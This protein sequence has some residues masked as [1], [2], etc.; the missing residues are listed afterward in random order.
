VFQT[1]RSDQSR[2]IQLATRSPYSHVGLVYVVD[3]E[4]MVFEAVVPVRLTPLDEW[5]ERGEGGRFVAKRLREADR[6]LTPD[7]R[8][9][10]LEIGRSFQGRPY[11]WRFA[12]TDDE[13]YCSELVWKMYRRALGIEVGRLQ[14]LGDFDL[15]DPEVRKMITRRWGGAVPWDETVVSPAAVFDSPLLELVHSKGTAPADGPG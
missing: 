11:D 4:A 13:L 7:A 6:L 12:W 2:A 9:R 14:T 8:D 1:S 3:G 5:I 10:L 15:S